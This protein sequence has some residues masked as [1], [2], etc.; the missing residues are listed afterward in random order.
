M[1]WKLKF[2]LGW[3]LYEY[4]I[5]LCFIWLSGLYVCYR[6]F[7]DIDIT[8]IYMPIKYKLIKYANHWHANVYEIYSSVH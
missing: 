4:F 3:V 2:M 6:I 8:L 7:H 1:W 5:T